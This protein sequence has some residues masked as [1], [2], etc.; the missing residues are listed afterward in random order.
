MRSL[1]FAPWMADLRVH[2]EVEPF[3]GFLKPRTQEGH[4]VGG[5]LGHLR[6]L[7]DTPNAQGTAT[8]R[9]YS[10]DVTFTRGRWKC[11]PC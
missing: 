7:S 10:G 4:T 8:R 1:S 9:T 6:N 3:S 5:T 2:S 11:R